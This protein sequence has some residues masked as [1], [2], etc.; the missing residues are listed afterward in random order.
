MRRKGKTTDLLIAIV[1]IYLFLGLG[2]VSVQALSGAPCG[3]VKLGGDYVYAVNA[4][5][6]GFWG[7]RAVKWLPIFWSNVI[8]GDVTFADFLS[9]K[10]CI[11]VPNGMTPAEALAKA[12][13][14]PLGAP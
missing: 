7:L 12:R 1:V 6:P 5:A 13:E 3:P 8:E 14:K 11:W 10:E 9:P 2:V 4:E